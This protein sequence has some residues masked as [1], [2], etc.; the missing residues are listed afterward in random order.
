MAYRWTTTEP[1]EQPARRM[2]LRFERGP[3]RQGVQPSD[4]PA[5][6]RLALDV[7]VQ[8]GGGQICKVREGTMK[9]ATVLT[10]LMSILATVQT[11]HAAPAVPEP[12][13]LT[14]VG[15]GGAA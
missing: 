2:R 11:A 15:V 9:R 6:G 7:P 8:G 4:S 1:P 5:I 12:A 13:T 14:L 10:I 3:D